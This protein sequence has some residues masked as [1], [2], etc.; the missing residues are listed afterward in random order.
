MEISRRASAGPL[1]P[2]LLGPCPF[3]KLGRCAPEP[4]GAIRNLVCQL[5][6]VA[7]P[8]PT[9]H[10]RCPFLRPPSPVQAGPWKGAALADR[11][12]ESEGRSTG[13][14]QLHVRFTHVNTQDVVYR[15]A[16]GG[17]RGCFPLLGTAT[18][19]L[20]SR[21]G[22]AGNQDPIP[23]GCCPLYPCLLGAAPRGPEQLQACPLLAL[24]TC[25][26]LLREDA[27]ELGWERG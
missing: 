20:A 27:L 16:G 7:A 15:R 17:C 9:C 8:D 4:R 24:A 25:L 14:A 18:F 11:N 13:Q 5:L 26:S 1:L 2:P 10:Q 19:F 3:W 21:V 23:L 6:R 12:Q 22:S